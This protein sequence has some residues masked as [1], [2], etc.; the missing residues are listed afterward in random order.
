MKKLGWIYA[1]I[2]IVLIVLFNL[3]GLNKTTANDENLN[4]NEQVVVVAES[5]SNEATAKDEAHTYEDAEEQANEDN[6]EDEAEEENEEKDA[7]DADNDEWDEDELMCVAELSDRAEL[8]L[9]RTGYLCS[10]NQDLLIPNW[11]GWVLTADHTDGTYKRN[12]IAFQ[13]D[14]DAPEPRVNTYDYTSSGYD[15]GHLCPSGDCK[16]NP[17]AQ[18]ESFLMTNICPQDHNLNCGDWNELEIACRKWA[19]R[20]GKL[21]IVCGPI[22]FRQKHKTIGKHKVTVP[23][24]FFKVI[25]RL[26]DDPKAIGFIYRNESGNR[27]INSYVNTVDQVERITG[28]DFFPNLPQPLQDEVESTADVGDWGR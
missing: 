6:T 8:Q 13:E 15:R 20:Y 14:M 2:I 10:Y 25:L 19:K 24:A 28:M 17:E 26:G 7:K 3:G 18:R 5:E 16:W 21:Y 1:C 11:V 4:D 9:R 23:E 12:G 22:L 27:K